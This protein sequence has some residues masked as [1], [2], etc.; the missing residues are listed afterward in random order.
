MSEISYSDINDD[1]LAAMRP[2]APLYYVV[3]GLLGAGIAAFFLTWLYQVKTGMGVAGISHP[4]GWGVYI[5]NFVFWVG[6]AH[7]GTLIS[8]ILHLL[9][10]KWRQAVSRPA[11][12]MTVFAVLT[13]G[14]FP[15]IHLGRFWVFYYILPYPSQ[16]QLWP[17]FTSPLVWDVCAVFT[18]LT[19]S[20]I[21]FYV[22]LIPDLAAARDHSATTW[23]EDHPR[24]RFYR[25][26]S[27]GWYGAASQW[28]H[29]GRAYLFFA[30]LA[31]PL[32]VSVHSVVSWDF[33]MGILPGWHTTIFP[34]Y[35]VAGAIHSG[36]AMVLTLMIPMRRLLH[37]ER[38]V[39]MQHF[40]AIAR[41]LVV[42]TAIVAYAYGVEPFI[43]WYT[44]GIDAQFA[45]WQ[46]SGAMAWAY[47]SLIPLN[48]LF[49]ALFM[50]PAVRR[51]IRLLFII[52]ILVNV[53]MWLERYSIITSATSHDFLPHNWGFYAP[54]WVEVTITAGSFCWF[55]FWF[56]VY[57]KTLPVVP[58]SELKELVAEEQADGRHEVP[59]L[60]P[61]GRTARAPQGVLAVY[62]RVDALLDAL[63]QV[64]AAG[65]ERLEV[66]APVKVGEI[67][68][69]LGHPR[70]PVRFWTLTGA[71]LGLTGGFALCLW[72]ASV[73]GLIVG[74]KPVNAYI[75][76]CIV[77][78]EGTI[79][80]G[81]LANLTGL[82]V[83][84][85]LGRRSTDLPAA[86]DRRFSQ[87]RFGIYIPC[88]PGG[89]ADAQRLLEHTHPES[90]RVVA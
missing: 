27:L 34:P 32:V 43:A 1:V 45:A 30:A 21:F 38:L 68:R 2:P 76:F 4:V 46:R 55:M 44:G 40:D 39:T 82:I 49:P 36:L 77:G 74:G 88:G 72:S 78:F 17:N 57:S 70:G 84:A 19:V 66:F 12:A 33:A 71:L 28:R 80:L 7:S 65:I 79:L 35:F 47:W 85:R 3:L 25:R 5:V 67:N 64:K 41:T 23:G 24:T 6:I 52:S 58:S 90:T 83:H 13:A 53:G 29:Y 31:T 75:P 51:N 16:R 42:T 10:S 37:L 81:T 61:V 14:L 60:Q 8:A 11:E 26:L 18:Y 59:P 48:V 22:G 56:L 63:W 89:R 87:T 69:I 73:N 50:F 9:R 15:L 86:Y 54:T 62:A 20:V